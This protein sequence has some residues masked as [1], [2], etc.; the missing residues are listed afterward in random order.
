M[1]GTIREVEN[2]NRGDSASAMYHP[3]FRC[4]AGTVVD[5]S[6]M[7]CRRYTLN[8]VAYIAGTPDT[9]PAHRMA[10]V[11][12]EASTEIG[13]DSVCKVEIKNEC[14]DGSLDMTK[15]DGRSDSVSSG[16][17]VT[18]AYVIL[19]FQKG[20]KI[21]ECGGLGARDA[22]V[23]GDTKE[24][25]GDLKKKVEEQDFN[26]RDDEMMK[27]ELKA[28]D[29]D[30]GEVEIERN[31]WEE[32]CWDL[33]TVIGTK[34]K[35]LEALQI[36]CN[37]AIRRSAF[38]SRRRSS[39]VLNDELL[40]AHQ[41]CNN[42]DQMMTKYSSLNTESWEIPKKGI[43]SFEQD[44]IVAVNDFIV[45]R[46]V[47]KAAW[48][49]RCSQLC[50]DVGKWVGRVMG[51]RGKT[52]IQ[53]GLSGLSLTTICRILAAHTLPQ[54][55]TICTKPSCDQQWLLNFVRSLS[56]VLAFAYCLSS[57]CLRLSDGNVHVFEQL[58][59][60]GKWGVPPPPIDSSS[61]SIV[62]ATSPAQ[63]SG[64]KQVPSGETISRQFNRCLLSI[65]KL[66]DVLLQKLQPIT[67]D[68]EDNRWKSFKGCL[69]ALD[70]T[71]IR[72]TPPSDQ[73]P[74]YRTRKADIAT[75]VLGVC[76][77]NMQFIYVLPGW[78]GSAHDGRVLRDAI[79]RPDGLKIPQS[80]Y[81]LVDAGYCNA[82]GFLA[83]FRGQR[84]HLNEFHGHRPQSGA[85]EYFNMKHSKARN[86]IERCF[87]LLKGR[88]KILASPSFFPITTQVYADFWAP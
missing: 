23:E 58:G 68:C 34:W 78:E 57:Y 83:S 10:I 20:G 39:L 52:T 66:H 60:V 9:S 71:S 27:R 79:S 24:A 38:V 44:Q 2:G 50:S 31:K 51:Q 70:G 80:C 33:N 13:C 11:A 40:Y 75:N 47:A 29:R 84:Y 18:Y 55:P 41:Y 87:G 63:G 76:C 56:T 42:D 59:S 17:I 15:L 48:V 4:A 49:K 73:K 45:E 12:T 6:D 3:D 61:T 26:M 22:E 53:S 14:G 54:Y 30:I 72:V 43:Q 37:Q 85:A 8:I 74:R 16:E 64:S 28:V 19:F 46:V 77:P 25:N 81:Y 32:K 5:F 35:E 1:V 21:V 7:C 88:W 65:L 69:S 62:A 86:V 36:E 82:P 67:D